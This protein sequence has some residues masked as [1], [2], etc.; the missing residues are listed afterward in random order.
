MNK[1]FDLVISN[2]DV[3][4][5]LQTLTEQLCQNGFNLIGD[6]LFLIDNSE[7]DDNA[8][9]NKQ[10]YNGYSELSVKI[11]NLCGK[12]G[13]NILSILSIATDENLEILLNEKDKRGILLSTKYD[14]LKKCMHIVKSIQIKGNY[15]ISKSNGEPYPKA[16]ATFINKN[17]ILALS[18]NTE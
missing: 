7:F 14:G 18:N 6:I 11:G 15:N 2:E 17:I 8:I 3:S 13:I 4:L 16:I 5:D 1:Y 10:K 9:H 12:H